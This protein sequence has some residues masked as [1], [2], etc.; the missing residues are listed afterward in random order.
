MLT[1]RVYKK[2]S[3]YLGIEFCSLETAALLVPPQ[4]ASKVPPSS[5]L[6]THVEEHGHLNQEHAT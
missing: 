6:Q 1:C 5:A 3:D 4:R 2:Y